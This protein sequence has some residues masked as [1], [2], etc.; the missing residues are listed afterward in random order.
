MGVPIAKIVSFIGDGHN[1]KKGLEKAIEK[2]ENA[3]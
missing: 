2:A 3:A 1:K